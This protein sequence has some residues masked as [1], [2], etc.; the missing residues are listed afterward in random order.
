IDDDD[1]PLKEEDE[2]SIPRAALNKFVKDVLP[3]A[4]LT[5]ETR[6]LLLSFCHK[7]IHTL[8]SQANFACSKLNK[9][10]INP[11]HILDALDAMGLSAYKEDARAASEEAKTELKDR[12][13]LSASYKF[14]HQ[15]SAE[16]ERLTKE[17][18]EIFEQARAQFIGETI[19]RQAL[20]HA[21]QST[22]HELAC[23]LSA[24]PLDHTRNGNEVHSRVTSVHHQPPSSRLPPVPI[25]PFPPSPRFSASINA[26]PDKVESAKNGQDSCPYFNASKRLDDF[27]PKVTGSARL[28]ATIDPSN[29][30]ENNGAE[31]QEADDDEDNYD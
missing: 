17:Q 26:S 3:E 19:D 9:K 21:S 16:L 12:R 27:L 25:T 14:K 18:Q 11:E 29:P 30:G 20:Y 10:T 15:D 23:P 2:V 13:M 1:L 22:F 8:A 28:V 5:N 24:S 31:C 6:D 7:F 4:R